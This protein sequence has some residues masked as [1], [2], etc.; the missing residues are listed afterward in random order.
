[1]I[2]TEYAEKMITKRIE[3]VHFLFCDRCKKMIYKR[4]SDEYAKQYDLMREHTKSV[5]WFDVTTGH[6][7]WGND[8][9]DSIMHNEYCRECLPK[10]FEHYLKEASGTDYFE[11]NHKQ[12][13]SLPMEQ[14]G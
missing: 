8:S 6:H 3:T 4:W 1:M 13:W 7:D 12:H 11:I 5:E 14:E 2:K 10:E 9:C